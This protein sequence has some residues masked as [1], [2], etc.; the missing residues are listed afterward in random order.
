M[1][2]IFSTIFPFFDHLYIFQLLEYALK[3]FFIWFL[4]HPANRSLQRKHKLE[5]TQKVKVLSFIGLT[6]ILILSSYT[7]LN[8]FSDLIYIPIFFLFY[9]IFS[10]VFIIFAQIIFYPFEIYQKN[11]IISEA[12]EKIANLDRLK[13]VAIVGS[14][15]KTSTKNILYTLLWKDF[16][17]IKT[18]KSFNTPVAIAR[19][20]LEDLKDT[21]EVFLVEMDAYHKGDISNLTSIAK[22]NL[23]VLTAIAAQHLSRF[24]S[25]EIL[26]KTQFEIAEALNKEGTLF[27]NSYDDW[28]MKLQDKYQVNK[29]FYGLRIKDD[30]SAT[31]IKPASI[32]FDFKF[33]AG[34]DSID[35]TIPLFGSHHILNFLAA[36][37]L[38]HTLG[39]SLKTIQ[40]RAL[41]IEPTPHRLEVT[42]LGDITLIDNSYN[43]NPT[44][45]K[46]SLKLLNDHPGDQ[47]ILI[48]PG[49]IELGKK[50]REENMSFAKDASKIADYIIIVGDN[51]KNY[52][53]EGLKEVDFP[54]A[55][56]IFAQSTKEAMEKLSKITIPN[57]V[58]LIEND[59]PD[60]YF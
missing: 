9:A 33:H 44:V 40:K 24:G 45:S 51:A 57:A 23:A 54:K 32:G 27:I 37:A 50:T 56:I 58:V 55:K 34:K 22:P 15:A 2:K 12:Q 47:K 20:I 3:D 25:M 4:K 49:L 60:Q 38:A 36:A 14:F 13:I 46:A 19:T 59:L 26:L 41:L 8:L 18:P 42:K 5:L 1:K 31:D 43:T 10:P 53:L 48:T 28:S 6:L 30:Y 11:K 17:V 29:K 35:I 16:N 21:T 52:L 39:V 7:S